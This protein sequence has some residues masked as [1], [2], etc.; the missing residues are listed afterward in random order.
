MLKYFILLLI[1]FTCLASEP[2]F[3][4]KDC[5][6]ITSGFYKGCRGTV[7]EFYGVDTYQVTIGNCRGS[8]FYGI[9][10]EDLL[11]LTKGCSK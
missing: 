9:F 2:K 8:S 5:V 6:K 3:H 4:F 7:E 1:A 11:Q 10:N